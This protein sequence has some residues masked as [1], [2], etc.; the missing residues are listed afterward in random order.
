MSTDRRRFITSFF[1]SA[2]SDDRKGHLHEHCGKLGRGVQDYLHPVARTFYCYIIKAKILSKASITT[3]FV[4][5]S[6][7]DMINLGDGS[8][9]ILFG[10][11]QNSLH[12][13]LYRE[14]FLV[15]RDKQIREN[16]C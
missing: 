16:D 15:R 11:L 6:F 9:M 3:L 13:M 4:G 7:H 12:T 14:N 10:W 2:T 1:V 8:I 5:E